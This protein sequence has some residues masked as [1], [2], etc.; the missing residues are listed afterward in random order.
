MVFKIPIL[1]STLGEAQCANSMFSSP[2][3]PKAGTTALYSYLSAHP[4]CFFPS[5]KEPTFFT[6]D[7]E[8][9][10]ILDME[11]YHSLYESA[12]AQHRVLCDGSPLY[13]ASRSAIRRVY[14][15]N[16]D[17]K[18][19]VI[20]RHPVDMF[21]S[22]FQQNLFRLREDARDPIEAWGLQDERKSGEC[23]PRRCR[24]PMMLQRQTHDF[25]VF[26]DVACLTSCSLR[27]RC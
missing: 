26:P 8:G 13:L 17:A 3:P 12:T 14:E 27:N 24:H 10:E 22:L 21:F 9:R 20:L 15:Y 25:P 5:V 23:I 2:A 7:D 6:D 19:V 11:T 1:L 4:Q 16:P 18:I